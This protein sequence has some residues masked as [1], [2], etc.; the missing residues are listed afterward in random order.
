VIVC[1]TLSDYVEASAQ[2][3]GTIGAA[4]PFVLAVDPHS[5]LASEEAIQTSSAT[6]ESS[7][8]VVEVAKTH[9]TTTHSVVNRNVVNH[10]MKVVR[11]GDSLVTSL[12]Q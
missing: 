7:R 10:N 5:F 9:K 12:E 2:F 11:R 8:G 1:S 3:G 6:S 4:Q